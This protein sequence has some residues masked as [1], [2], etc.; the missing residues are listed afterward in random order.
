MA[1]IDY[2]NLIHA[3]E[4]AHRIYS[5]CCKEYLEAVSK[6]TDPTLKA[7]GYKIVRTLNESLLSDVDSFKQQQQGGNNQ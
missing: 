6:E 2:E 5:E 3:L 4:E 7:T 1:S